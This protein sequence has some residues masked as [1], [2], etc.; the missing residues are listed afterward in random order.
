M[1]GEQDGELVEV[2]RVPVG[3][4]GRAWSSSMRRM[5]WATAPCPT[6]SGRTNA[7]RR[8]AG[9]SL[10]WTRPADSMT[11]SWRLTAA[12]SIRAIWASSAMALPVSVST[13]ASWRCPA[14]TIGPATSARL[15]ETR[16][17]RTAG[18][19]DGSKARAAVSVDR[20]C[21]SD[22][23]PLVIAPRHAGTVA[24]VHRPV[25]RKGTRHLTSQAT[26]PDAV[27]VRRSR[28]RWATLYRSVGRGSGRQRL[29]WPPVDD[30]G[31]DA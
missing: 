30:R 20:S 24:A 1:P 29:L 8:S 15:A 14:G 25:A 6:G 9:A 11:R 13:R 18:R 2:T 5:R 7:T 26:R 31:F 3:E 27:G 17:W 28:R 21:R 12:R 10:R 16:G 23:R 22:H 4:H 19:V